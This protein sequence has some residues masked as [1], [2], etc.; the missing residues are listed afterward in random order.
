[1]NCSSELED[2]LKNHKNKTQNNRNEV[3]LTEGNH[4]VLDLKQYGSFYI[5]KKLTRT[6]SST[7]S[8][9]WHNFSF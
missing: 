7:K 3:E 1:M 4:P 6:F 5:H 8:I 9:F 2:S